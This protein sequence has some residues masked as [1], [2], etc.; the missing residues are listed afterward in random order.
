MT[1]QD[2]DL[3][4]KIE[5]AKKE[6]TE[7]EES[8]NAENEEINKIKAEL[9]QMTE[10]AKRTMADLQNLRRHQEEERRTLITVGNVDLIK[11]LLPVLD[12]L[13]RS[14]AHLP[15]AASGVDWFG[16]WFKGVEI[17]IGQLH[18][19]MEESGLKIIESIGQK[20]NPDLHEAFLE[21]PGEKD[22]IT[23][24]LEKGYLIGDRVLRHAKVKVG[25][26]E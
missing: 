3:Q 15:E 20:F 6:A 22:I 2:I 11:K 14:K 24:E 5:Q 1:D 19:I 17:S 23:E 25:N 7:K 8:A 9:E 26:G 16:E 12:N 13:D 18:K 4:K 21:G 10:L